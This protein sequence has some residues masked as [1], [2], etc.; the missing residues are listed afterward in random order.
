[1]GDIV[2]IKDEFKPT[3]FPLAIVREIVENRLGEVTSASIFKGSSR[4]L[5]KR[6]V[7]SLIPLLSSDDSAIIADPLTSRKI[8]STSNLP[9]SS[10]P[11]RKTA[12]RSKQ[13]W[14][15]LKKADLV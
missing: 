13:S 10:R 12:E 3:N 8:D 5:V 15:Q 4:E 9:S 6:H 14:R 11:V 7:T 1:M 2:L